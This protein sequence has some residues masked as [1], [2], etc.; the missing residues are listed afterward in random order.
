LSRC[1]CGPEIINYGA[2]PFSAVAS[3]PDLNASTLALFLLH[4]HP[5]MPDMGLSR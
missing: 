3:K 1:E 4:P 5:K 2:P